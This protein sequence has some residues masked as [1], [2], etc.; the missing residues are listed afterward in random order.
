MILLFVNA[1]LAKKNIILT[2]NF[3]ANI[4]NLLI[5]VFRAKKHKIVDVFFLIL[6]ILPH[7]IEILK[8]CCFF[9]NFII[10]FF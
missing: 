3:I 8:N 6:R 10:I 7:F 9:K 4:R 2:M 1:L 5:L